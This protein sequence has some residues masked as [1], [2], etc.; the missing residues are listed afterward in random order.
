M[1]HEERKDR[2]KHGLVTEDNNRANEVKGRSSYD[3]MT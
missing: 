1:K 2:S 3:N